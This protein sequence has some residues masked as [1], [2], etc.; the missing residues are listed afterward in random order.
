MPPTSSRALPRLQSLSAQLNPRSN[1]WESL[2]IHRKSTQVPYVTALNPVRFLLRSALVYANKTAVIHRNRSF[3]YC[4]F[5]DR[6]QKLANVLLDMGVKPGDRVA[7]LAQNIPAALEATYAVPSV[8]A[9]LVP[10]NT[11]LAMKEIDYIIDHCDANILLYQDELKDRVSSRVRSSLALLHVTDGEIESDPYED[12]LAK[13]G[14]RSWDELPLVEDEMAPISLNYTSGS[15]GRPKG[16]LTLYRGAYLASL[17][18]VIH[19]QLTSESVYLWTLPMFHCNGWNFPWAVVAVGGTQVMLNKLDYT[20]IWKQLKEQGVTHYNAAPTVQNELCNHVDAARLK[21]PVRCFAGGAALSDTL[22]QRMR[23]LNLEP[24]QVY[25]LTETYGPVTMSYDQVLLSQYPENEQFLIMARQGYNSVIQDEIRV[26]DCHGVDVKPD[27]KTIGEI[28]TSGNQTMG[29]YYKD[30]AET[31][32][33]FRGGVFWTGD[34]AVRHSD[35]SI[36]IVDRSKDVIISGGENISSIEVENA[37]TRLEAISECAIVGG[38]DDKWG[39]RP[40]AFVTLRSGRSVT[41]EEVIYHCRSE[42]AGYKVK[43]NSWKLNVN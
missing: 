39:E 12:L 18:M 32:R 35:G 42:L 30:E 37:I 43:K 13:A 17:A 31:Q 9:V 27:G 25:G 15:T 14:T 8:G 24:I 26:L 21:C 20:I 10:L 6:V 33:C 23:A 3:T 2:R 34:L 5:A 7:I 22:I 1:Q 16:V 19:S 40:Y 38:P 28:C 29:G 11:R 41:P 4:E 36:E